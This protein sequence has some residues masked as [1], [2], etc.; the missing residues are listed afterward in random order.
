MKLKIIFNAA[1]FLAFM[2]HNAQN[3]NQTKE[4]LIGRWK[5]IKV[6]DENGKKIKRFIKN[7]PKFGSLFPDVIYKENGKIII[8]FPDDKNPLEGNWQWISDT[9]IVISPKD[10]D[11]KKDTVQIELIK[12]IK[13]K[14]YRKGEPFIRVYKKK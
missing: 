4:N 6:I 14:F 8:I 3:L 9:K 11:L 7:G 2:N 10:Q 5:H 13:M 12:K 1:L